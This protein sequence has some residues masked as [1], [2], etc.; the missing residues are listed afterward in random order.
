MEIRRWSSRSR[1]SKACDRSTQRRKPTGQ[2]ETVTKFLVPSHVI[3]ADTNIS[4]DGILTLRRIRSRERDR[5]RNQPQ[6]V[7]RILSFVHVFVHVLW[8]CPRFASAVDSALIRSGNR[9]IRE[10]CVEINYGYGWG[11]ITPHR[12]KNEFPQPNARIKRCSTRS[13]RSRLLSHM[14][15]RLDCSCRLARKK[16]GS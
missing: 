11:W 1:Y 14:R 6:L 15:T 10:C 9:N 8:R 7:H 13:V 12:S 4:V 5:C 2:A 3:P 16:P